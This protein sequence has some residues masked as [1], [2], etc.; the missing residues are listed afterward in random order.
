MTQSP[1]NITI[2]NKKAYHDYFV[3][4]T[5]ECG[6]ALRGNEVKSIRD[7]KASIKEAWVAI[8]NG[9]VTI[10][11]MHITA[12]G[13]TNKFDVDEMRDRRLLLH[14]TEIL[15]LEK[16][17]KQNGY[18]LIPLKMYFVNG[19][20]KVLVGLARGKHDYDKRK[21]LKDKQVQRDINRVLKG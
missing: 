15:N 19:R 10:K 3:E 6:I 14:K 2:E 13:K 17:I 21:T 18:T 12:W 8:K 11:Q 4:E 1:K 5:T 7:G 9:Q 16:K 20:C